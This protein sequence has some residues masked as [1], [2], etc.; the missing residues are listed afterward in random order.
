MGDWS[1]S[2][3]RRIQ[4]IGNNGRESELEARVIRQGAKG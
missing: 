1:E 3:H 4:Q 2:V